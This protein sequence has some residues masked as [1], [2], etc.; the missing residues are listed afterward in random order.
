MNN[1]N[2]YNILKQAHNASFKYNDIDVIDSYIRN[3]AEMKGIGIN[4]KLNNKKILK[5]WY[6]NK[7]NLFKLLKNNLIYEFPVQ[8][9]FSFEEKIEIMK[10][11]LTQNNGYL[12][13]N[14]FN[15][16]FYNKIKFNDLYLAIK[17]AYNIDNLVRNVWNF[18]NFKYEIDNNKL[19][20]CNGMKITTAF[21]K[22]SNCF[23]LNYYEQF[24]L[25]HSQGNNYNFSNEI[26]YL[27][28]HP[29]DYFTLSDNKCG[30]DSCLSWIKEGGN[31]L[32]TIELMNNSSAIVAYIKSKNDIEIPK[33]TWNNK[34]WRELFFVNE[35][36]IFE[37]KA[38]PYRFDEL[39]KII[40]NKIKELANLN[41]E[42][43]YTLNYNEP[44]EIQNKKIIFNP[45]QHY[46]YNDFTI[47]PKTVGNN[48]SRGHYVY[49]RENFLK[50]KI[51]IEMEYEPDFTGKASC[52]SCGHLIIN[53]NIKGQESN[54][55]CY[56]CSKNFKICSICGKIV[57]NNNILELETTG[58]LYCED[59]YL[60]NVFNDEISLETY[61][62]S[63]KMIIFC[64]KN[65]N[66][67]TENDRKI[68][69]LKL[70]SKL[71]FSRNYKLIDYFNKIHK[72]SIYINQIKTQ[73][74]Y[75]NIEDIKFNFLNIL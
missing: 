63:E 39:S 60:N 35:D 75:V 25:A 7:I 6:N 70:D 20:L 45:K 33:G 38:Y 5:N 62:N 61:P 46:M 15:A 74:Y 34:K 13:M 12:L 53:K 73:I 66:N 49:F 29:L 8:I 17:E 64:A 36:G 58:D 23:K 18:G 16:Y 2:L 22:I 26:I 42:E 11:F 52:L 67:P 3:Y 65:K 21:K 54:I 4:R 48:Q 37:S 72:K 1:L 27:S 30:W 24:R 69:L 44:T 28:I 71:N 47:I 68:E 14:E 40:I 32:G 19:I 9:S 10:K 56:K 55:F 41:I 31:C 51:D 57:Y 50:N 43:L 59:C